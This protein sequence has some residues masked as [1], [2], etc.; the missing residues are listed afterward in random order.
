MRGSAFS[1]SNACRVRGSFRTL[2][3]RSKTTWSFAPRQDGVVPMRQNV[4]SS[5]PNR[6]LLILR[7]CGCFGI[8]RRVQ[9]GPTPQPGL[10][11]RR[12]D[13]VQHRL[14]A[15][16]GLALPVCTDGAEQPV[17]DRVP[18]RRARRIVRH[19]DSD[20]PPIGQLLQGPPPGPTAWVVAA[21]AVSRD[22]P[23]SRPRVTPTSMLLPPGA[24]GGADERRRFARRP[25]HHEPRVALSVVDAEWDRFADTP[26]G[27]VVV[28]HVLSLASPGSTRILEQ[29][30]DLLFL[31][32]DADRRISVLSETSPQAGDVAELAI[33]FRL[34]VAGQPL[35]IGSQRVAGIL[36][37]ATHRDRADRVA[38][39]LQGPRQLTQRAVG[40]PQAAHRIAR[41]GILDERSQRLHHARV[42]FSTGRRPPPGC[43]TRSPAAAVPHRNS[44]MPRRTVVRLKPVIVATAT[45]PP[46]PRRMANRPANNRRCRSSSR[47]IT[48]LMAAW[49]NATALCGSRRQSPQGHR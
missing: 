40:P 25:D 1:T 31:G 41:R 36:E 3:A 14:V 10:R 6:P 19:R 5:D 37:Q 26:T 48:R 17:L 30:D 2:R 28:I 9:H 12:A 20:A 49:S 23:V 43:R 47:A 22:Q 29:A 15:L 8:L 18:F 35:A 4:C 42:F 45:M 27:E 39:L 13:V 24:H 21:A 44:S 16:E 7:D 46:C 11:G 32:I 34:L 38:L 33:P